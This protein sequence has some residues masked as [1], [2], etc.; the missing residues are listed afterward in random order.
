MNS[1]TLL[2]AEGWNGTR[3]VLGREKGSSMGGEQG[4]VGT[5]SEDE[6]GKGTM[7]GKGKIFVIG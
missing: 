7:Y 2:L 4:D 6:S 3:L 5:N 1:L